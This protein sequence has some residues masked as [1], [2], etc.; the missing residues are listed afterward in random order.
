MPDIDEHG[1]HLLPILP[2]NT[3]LFACLREA[4][5]YLATCCFSPSSDMAA[6][7]YHGLVRRDSVLPSMTFGVKPAEKMIEG[8]A[9]QEVRPLAADPIS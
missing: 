2:V 5:D 1:S 4:H 8:Q 7:L 6:V 3:T 9:A